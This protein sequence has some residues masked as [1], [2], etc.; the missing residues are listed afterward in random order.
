MTLDN[1]GKIADGSLDF[2]IGAL[3]YHTGRITSVTSLNIPP[4]LCSLMLPLMG[5]ALPLSC[6]THLQNQQ[7]LMDAGPALQKLQ[8][9]C[10][11]KESSSPHLP[12]HDPSSTLHSDWGAAGIWT[13]W[14]SHGKQHLFSLQ[15]KLPTKTICF[16]IRVQGSFIDIFLKS[17]Y[18][19][20]KELSSGQMSMRLH[21]FPILQLFLLKTFVFF[22]RKPKCTHNAQISTEEKAQNR[23]SFQ[24][25]QT[26]M[27]MQSWA[28]ALS[29]RASS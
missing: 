27:D 2:T 19:R 3:P 9:K 22:L 12:F 13:L 25:S 29:Q 18:P 24:F 26:V 21:K 15:S 6:H 17:A 7:L 5:T 20:V 14:P 1:S 4:F 16:H 28:P 23:C 11:N 10:G 8:L